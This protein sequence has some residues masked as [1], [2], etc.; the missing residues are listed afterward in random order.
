MGDDLTVVNAARASFDAESKWQTFIPGPD[1]DG[2]PKQLYAKDEKLLNFCAREKHWSPF[3]H[4]QVHL[5]LYIPGMVLDQWVKHRIGVSISDDEAFQAY[6]NEGTN[7]LSL[8]YKEPKDFYIPEVWRTAPDNKK[9]GSGPDMYHA[10]SNHLSAV[11][12]D[13]VRLGVQRYEHAI[14]MGA[15]PEQA[16]LFIPYYAMYTNRRW[17]SSLYGII[18]LLSLRLEKDSQ[19]EIRQYAN[20]VRSLVQ[21]LFPY[22]FRAF[23]LDVHDQGDTE[24]G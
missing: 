1:G 19:Y 20:A 16:R 17:T 13:A 3:S 24:Q 23:G 15:A 4:P 9:Q 14:E 12:R 5:E 7:Q 8:R 21:P 18:N 22:S 6:Q 10:D 2:A 11:M